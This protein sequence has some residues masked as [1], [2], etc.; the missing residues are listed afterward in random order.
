[1]VFQEKNFLC[2]ILLSQSQSKFLTHASSCILS[3]STQ[4]TYRLLKFN[5]S[6]T[7][8]TILATTPLL[9]F[10]HQGGRLKPS[11]PFKQYLANVSFMPGKVPGSSNRAMNMT[12]LYHVSAILNL[13]HGFPTSISTSPFSLGPCQ[14]SCGLLNFSPILTLFLSPPFPTMFFHLQ[15]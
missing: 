2:D 15:S 3:L 10:S 1:M 5:R 12:E 13:P 8:S 7:K 14:S 9:C 6:V 4:M 11:S